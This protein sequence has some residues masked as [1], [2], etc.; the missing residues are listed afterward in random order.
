MNFRVIRTARREG[1]GC[2]DKR[3]LFP[4]GRAIRSL[5]LRNLQCEIREYHEKMMMVIGLY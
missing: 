4:F 5:S 3:C 1:K 2:G